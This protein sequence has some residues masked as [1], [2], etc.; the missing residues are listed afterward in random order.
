MTKDYK[1]PCSAKRALTP[2]QKREKCLRYLGLKKNG[3]SG[4]QLSRKSGLRPYEFRELAAQC[5]LNVA[6]RAK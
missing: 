1:D 3:W 4:N 2:E 5:G 6:D